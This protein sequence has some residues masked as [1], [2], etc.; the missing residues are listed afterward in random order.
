M[1]KDKW[2]KIWGV[3][4]PSF[5][6]FIDD[7]IL[8]LSASLAYYT[9]FAMGP[10]LFMV[11]LLC[12]FIYGKDAV[13]GRVLNELT[14]FIGKETAQQVQYIIKNAALMGKGAL[15]AVVGGALLLISATSIFAEIQDSLNIIWSVKSKPKNSFFKYLQIRFLSF[16]IIIGLGFLAIVSLTASALIDGLGDK[17]AMHYKWVNTLVL[18]GANLIFTIAIIA[19]IFAVMFKVLPDARINWRE[20]FVGS[21]VTAILFVL[22]KLAISIY[23]ANSRIA[24]YYGAA[25]TVI[26][27]LL[28][29]Y[30]CSVILY[31][32]AEFTKAHASADGKEIEP[33]EYAVGIKS[34]E[35]PRRGAPK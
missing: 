5:N 10:L 35:I 33:A 1:I 9:I 3:L 13:E 23:I 21:L 25:G 26:I 31:Y 11:I 4:G 16:S 17:I 20:V 24:T 14:G 18:H 28:W 8:K 32:G 7:K 19:L 34:V 22:G 12:G 29:V 6:G 27:V 2:I 15:A 30:Y